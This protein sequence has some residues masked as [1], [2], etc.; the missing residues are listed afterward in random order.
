MAAQFEKTKGKKY[1]PKKADKSR[2]AKPNHIKL[3][4]TKPKKTTGTIT[5]LTSS[6]VSSA[7]SSISTLANKIKHRKKE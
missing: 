2:I 6:S 5:K 4:Q 1:V 3:L 7:L